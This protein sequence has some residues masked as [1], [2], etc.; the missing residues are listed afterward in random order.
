M[1]PPAKERILLVDDNPVN[2]KVLADAL[3]PEGYSILVARGGEAALKV[4]VTGAPD[5]ILLDVM[6]PVIDGIETCRRLK[7]N[8][9][10]REIPVIFISARN[11]MESVVSGFRAGGI[12]YITKPFQAEE[13]LARVE[14]H[15]KRV[16]LTRELLKKNEELS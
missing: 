11:E 9:A 2:L 12:D 13:V 10:T 16:R 1:N 8:E 4:A 5:L 6:M 7:E 15:L 3:E 14:N